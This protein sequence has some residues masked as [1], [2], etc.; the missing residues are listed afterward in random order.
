[1][2]YSNTELQKLQ[3]L[4]D[5]QGELSS[6]DEKKYRFLKRQCEREL[7]QVCVYVS[8]YVCPSSYLYLCTFHIHCQSLVQHQNLKSDMHQT[9]SEN[10]QSSIN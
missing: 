10:F 2:L 4:K 3:Q 9:T 7:L 1:M 8:I 5:D 6:S